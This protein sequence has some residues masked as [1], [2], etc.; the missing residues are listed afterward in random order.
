MPAAHLRVLTSGGDFTPPMPVSWASGRFALGGDGAPRAGGSAIGEP[1]PA[2]ARRMHGAWLIPGLVD[3]H[4]HASWHAFDAADRARLD[5]DATQRAT[6]AALARTVRAGITSLRDAGGLTPAARDR[7]SAHDRP[8][9]ALSVALL[10]R[11]AADSAGGLDRAVAEVLDAGARWV[12]LVATS[13]VAA[14]AGATL[15]SHFSRA[16]FA[17]AV[18]RAS[19]A[20]AGVMVHAWG[21]EAID[22]AIATGAASIEH[23]MYLPGAQA[24]RAADAGLTFVPTLRIYRLVREMIAGGELPAALSARVDDAVARHPGAVRLARDAGL[25]IA[26]GTDAGTAE[27][28]GAN[29][30]EFDA[31]VAAG[32]T[33]QEALVAATRVGAELLLRAAD[34]DAPPADRPTGVIAEGA[35]ADAVVLNRDPRVPGALADPKSIVGVLLGG[36]WIEPAAGAPDSP[37]THTVSRED[38]P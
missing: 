37:Q 31:L 38:H 25:P 2:E 33:P 28:H 11:A 8:R 27:Q 10:D 1:A 35:V 15:E 16:E 22:H 23:G 34:P 13:G 36:R 12:K 9:S 14:P 4:V 21:G 29:R 7:I 24:A 26:L 30:R 32:L 5:S 17:A 3:A 19:R 6:A 20:G 18:A